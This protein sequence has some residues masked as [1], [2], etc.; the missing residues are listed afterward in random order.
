M[1]DE[2]E[3]QGRSGCLEDED[4]FTRPLAPPPSGY[5][6]SGCVGGLKIDSTGPLHRYTTLFLDPAGSK[7][8]CGEYQRMT[9]CKF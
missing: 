9:P 7:L 4:G 8:N 2:E 5:C 3:R 6:S 1:L